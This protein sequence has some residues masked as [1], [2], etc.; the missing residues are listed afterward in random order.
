MYFTTFAPKSTSSNALGCNVD[1]GQATAYA[2]SFDPSSLAVG[3]GEGEGEGDGDGNGEP[4]YTPF[5]PGIESS[6]IITDG[7]PPAPIELS[8][9]PAG[10]IAFCEDNPEHVSC[11]TQ[12]P[13]P[14][15]E[16]RGD[17]PPP[18]PACEASVSVI[19]S[20]TSVI[21]NGADQCE[22]LK[23]NYWRSL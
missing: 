4:P 1:V 3:E 17:C 6:D 18:P 23:R 13:E 14:G 7:P 5:Y 10:Q 2:I 19:L 16:D 20:G 9:S 8:V 15:C 21:S 22:L 12:E 11:K